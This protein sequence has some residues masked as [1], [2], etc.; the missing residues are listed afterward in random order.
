M[1]SVLHQQFDELI[2]YIL[3]IVGSDPKAYSYV[4]NVQFFMQ[5]YPPNKLMASIIK[6]LCP[7]QSKVQA[8]DADY[9]IERKY[10]FDGLPD[11]S[12]DYFIK[13][14]KSGVLKDDEYQETIFKFV[15]NFIECAEQYVKNKKR[16]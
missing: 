13:I 12:V 16:V 9:F 7:H 5:Q 10:I 6:K 8:R 15:D 1:E 14:W 4:T 3:A 11:D 2:S